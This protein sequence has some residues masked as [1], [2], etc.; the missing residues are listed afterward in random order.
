[1]PATWRTARS[2]TSGESL[3]GEFICPVLPKTQRVEFPGFPGRFI[4]PA[5]IG[6]VEIFRVD[7]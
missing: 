6:P 3:V 1:M 2:R 7:G 4:R 5:V